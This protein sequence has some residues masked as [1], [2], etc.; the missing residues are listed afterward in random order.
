MILWSGSPLERIDMSCWKLDS[1]P[2]LQKNINWL[3][4]DLQNHE[5]HEEERS[6]DLALSDL[7]IQEDR[8][9]MA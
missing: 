6:W 8:K 9:L 3:L 5:V 4:I 1:P 7:T 2:V